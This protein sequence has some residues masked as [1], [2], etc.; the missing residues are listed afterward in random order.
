MP[1]YQLG[2][3]Y[4]LVCNVTG[5]V[6]VGSTCEKSLARRLAGHKATYK[7][8]LNQKKK[9]MT[10]FKVLEN[11][12]YDIV[13]IEKYPCDS[14][15]EL[16]K[17]ERIYIESINCVNKYIP[18]KTIDERNEYLKIYEENNKEKRKEK[19]NKKFDCEC[20]SKYTHVNKSHHHKTL[21]HINFCQTII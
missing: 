4:K 14:K 11:D 12:N 7:T 10:S 2:K 13:L 20:G 17:K 21:K 6:Y 8:Y 19:M 18:C 16:H 5:L 1:D 3:I 9:F 15:E